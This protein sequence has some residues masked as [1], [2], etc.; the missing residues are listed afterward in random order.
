MHW[1]DEYYELFYKSLFK[2]IFRTRNLAQELWR[3]HAR[4]SE[5][6][7]SQKNDYAKLAHMMANK[8]FTEDYSQLAETTQVLRNVVEILALLIDKH[9]TRPGFERFVIEDLYELED[10]KTL[11]LIRKQ[12]ERF[13]KRMERQEGLYEKLC[14]WGQVYPFLKSGDTYEGGVQNQAG[15]L[16]G[17]IA[18]H[19]KINS[20]KLH[21]A[22][23]RVLKNKVSERIRMI[24]DL[25]RQPIGEEL[26]PYNLKAT[27]LVNPQPDTAT[28]L[29]STHLFS[30]SEVPIPPITV[31]SSIFRGLHDSLES[32]DSYLQV[33]FETYLD[34]ERFARVSQVPEAS[35]YAQKIREVVL[36]L[37][38]EVMTKSSSFPEAHTYV[39]TQIKDSKIIPIYQIEKDVYPKITPR[40]LLRYADQKVFSGRNVKKFLLNNNIKHS[41]YY[42]RNKEVLEVQVFQMLI[43][44][45]LGA[46]DHL[47]EIRLEMSENT[48]KLGVEKY[49]KMSF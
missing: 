21:V 7:T 41:L 44:S 31:T 8:I 16:V 39:S 1:Y 36:Y 37:R 10:I 32:I 23:E 14:H 40:S 33:N 12:T 43:A 4:T 17:Y 25:P 28:N 11:G 29:T 42:P 30:E 13:L 15:E 24:D 6:L 9:E 45:I 27:G 5:Y 34:N 18:P 49:Q 19:Y 3:E 2:S 48:A 20:A 38:Q 35:E 47:Q 22:T 46:V 26:A